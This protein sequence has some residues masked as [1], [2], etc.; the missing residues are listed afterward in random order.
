M[1]KTKITKLERMLLTLMLALVLGAPIV[2]IAI[3]SQLFAYTK[4]ITAIDNELEEL[5]QRSR[6]LE[7]KKQEKLAYTEV[8]EYAARDNLAATSNNYV[9][10]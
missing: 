2:T 9:Q 10:I 5:H 1:K 3:T 6:E 8:R 7:V 4:Q